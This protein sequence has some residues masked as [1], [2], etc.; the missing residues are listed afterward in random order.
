MKWFGGSALIPREPSFPSVF[1]ILPF[2][3]PSMDLPTRQIPT[4]VQLCQRSG[5]ILAKR[6]Q[7]VNTDLPRAQ[8]LVLM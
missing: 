4:L 1:F 8:L 7:F 5:Y 2:K 3:R 6:T